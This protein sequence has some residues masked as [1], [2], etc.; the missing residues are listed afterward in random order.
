[1]KTGRAP[2]RTNA[3]AVETKVNDGK[4]HLVAGLDIEQQRGH[5]EGVRAG[6]G[7]QDAG[8]A[9]GRLQQLLAQLGEVAVARN[10]AA[11]D[12]LADVVELLAEQRGLVERDLDFRHADDTNAGR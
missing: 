6:S 1:M 5:L 11:L 7:Q 8:S 10:L 3:L 9:S 2:R 4:N 12:R